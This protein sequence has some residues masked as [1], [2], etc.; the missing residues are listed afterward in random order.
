MFGLCVLRAKWICR[1]L[2]VRKALR[3]FACLN[4]F[5]MYVVSLPIYANV[6][7]LRLFSCGCCDGVFWECIVCGM[8]EDRR[9]D[10]EYFV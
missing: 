6:V 8:I 7:H 4:M 5:V 9:F 1:V 10:G 2:L 3:K